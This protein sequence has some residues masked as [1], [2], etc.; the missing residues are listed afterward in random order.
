[1]TNAKKPNQIRHPMPVLS[2][3]IIILFMVPRKRFLVPSNWSFI[4]SANAVLSLISVPMA[5]V[6]CYGQSSFMKHPGPTHIFQHSHSLG[7]FANL[8]LI[9]TLQ[10]VQDRS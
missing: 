6:I 4:F 9:L 8:L 10:L 2:A 7:H 5:T 3:I 1:M